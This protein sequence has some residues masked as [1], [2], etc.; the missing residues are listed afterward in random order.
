MRTSVV[1][2]IMHLSEASV[3]KRLPINHNSRKRHSEHEAGPSFW[4]LGFAAGLLE[5]TCT[6]AWMGRG[7]ISGETSRK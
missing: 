3:N 1:C 4:S 5:V 6:L 2:I 7:M